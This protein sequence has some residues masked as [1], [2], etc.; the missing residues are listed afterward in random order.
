[1]AFEIEVQVAVRDGVP[2][3]RNDA[4]LLPMSAILP[5]D[6]VTIYS[7]ITWSEEQVYGIWH[8]F[9]HRLASLSLASL[10]FISTIIP[11]LAELLSTAI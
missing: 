2:V 1:M 10:G 3:S 9:H 4:A 11:Q 6:K 5:M 7:G 8:L